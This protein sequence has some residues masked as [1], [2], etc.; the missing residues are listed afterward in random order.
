MLAFVIGADNAVCIMLL[1]L[2]LLFFA[3]MLLLINDERKKDRACYLWRV[4]RY[5]SCTAEKEKA[6]KKGKIITISCDGEEDSG[7]TEILLTVCC[8]H[9]HPL[10]CCRHQ[11]PWP[12]IPLCRQFSCEIIV[13]MIFHRYVDI[14]TFMLSVHCCAHMQ[15]GRC[16]VAHVRMY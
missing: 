5:N 9:H 11:R 6:V 15:F 7:D 1:L 8:T 16:F 12:F 4:T 3:H 10:V 14:Q 2:L 13:G